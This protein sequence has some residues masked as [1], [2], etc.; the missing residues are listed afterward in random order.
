MRISRINHIGVL[1]RDLDR[2]RHGFES[3]LGLPLARSERFGDELDIEFL[4]CGDTDV[5]LITPIAQQGA[6]HEYLEAHGPSIQHVAF[7]VPDLEAALAE[8]AERGV[9]PTGDGIRRGAGDTLI[10]FLDPEPFGGII[11]E[12]CQPLP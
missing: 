10:A 5:E 2:A 7:E 8:L 3:V 12:L 1:V 9:L 6:N 4:P 11:V